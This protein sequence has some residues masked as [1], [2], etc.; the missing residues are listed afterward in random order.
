[1]DIAKD[2]RESYKILVADDDSGKAVRIQDILYSGGY[3]NIK[4][5]SFIESFHEL[6]GYDI[7]IL[8]ICWPPSAR[9]KCEESDYFGLAG[10]DY[11]R[12]NA[13]KTKVILTSSYLFDLEH[14]EK[15][16]DADGYFMSN[17]SASKI[18]EKV[19]KVTNNS[20]RVISIQKSWGVKL[21][22]LLELLELTLTDGRAGLFGMENDR[23]KN[24]LS[25]THQLNQRVQR[26]ELDSNELKDQ[27]KVLSQ[28]TLG[29][30][31]LTSI[32]TEIQK[33]MKDN[34][35]NQGT[36]QNI[37][38]AERGIALAFAGA[39]LVTFIVLV[40]NPRLMNGGT[41]AIVRFLAAT[42]A[43]IAGYLFAG[44]LGLEAKVPLNKTQ[45][46]ATG[47]FAAFVLVLF[48]FFVGVPVIA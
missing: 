30:S 14:I 13:P 45:I 33:L 36:S 47:A 2:F 38:Y 24:L 1:M 34:K 9:P 26:S 44:N 37:S 16:Q 12:T 11:L 21:S 39:V 43:G 20:G 41:L 40:L 42:F 8:D 4:F 48:I 29:V 23:Y 19:S 10:L 3:K 5:T 18:L 46:R 28:L 17:M 31:N 27:V 25:R 32:V 7:V 22:E 15:I 35:H 6:E